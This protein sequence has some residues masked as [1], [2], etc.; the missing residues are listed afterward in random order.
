MHQYF[1]AAGV[2]TRPAQEGLLAKIGDEAI[3]EEA[4]APILKK[5][6]AGEKEKAKKRWIEYLVNRTVFSKEASLLNG[7]I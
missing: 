3:T 7:Q 2:N 1:E 4:L 5:I 6:P